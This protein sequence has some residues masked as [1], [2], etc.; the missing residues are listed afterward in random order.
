MQAKQRPRHTEPGIAE[1]SAAPRGWLGTPW[2]VSRRV[3]WGYRPATWQGWGLTALLVLFV[4]SA[5][6]LLRAHHAALFLISLVVLC[7]VYIA[8]A[9]VTSRA[10]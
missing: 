9:A 3:G 10:L 6:S 7:V 2:F 1:Q 8:L 5:S 4:I